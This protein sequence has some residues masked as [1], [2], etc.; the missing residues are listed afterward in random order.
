MESKIGQI[1]DVPEKIKERWR[2]QTDYPCG[3]FTRC[4]ECG[5]GGANSCSIW[6]GWFRR[7]WISIKLHKENGHGGAPN[8]P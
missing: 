5:S 1:P 2:K 6:S 3:R 4:K 8:E 7:V